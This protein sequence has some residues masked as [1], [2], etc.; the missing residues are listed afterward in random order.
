MFILK[1]VKVLWFD[2]LLQVLI[3]KGVIGVAFCIRL[4]ISGSGRRPLH[5][6]GCFCERVWICLIAKDLTSLEAT[7]SPQEYDGAGLASARVR[8]VLMEASMEAQCTQ[9]ETLGYAGSARRLRREGW[10]AADFMSYH[11]AKTACCQEKYIVGELLVRTDSEVVGGARVIEDK[12][13]RN[14]IT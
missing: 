13:A 14:A 8:K 1:I 6:P 10:D 9:V 7:K 3:L 4:S 2:T 11:C 5:P 12:Y